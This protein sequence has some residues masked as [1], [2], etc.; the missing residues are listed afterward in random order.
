MEFIRDSLQRKAGSRAAVMV[1]AGF[2][3]N[4]DPVSPSA[5]QM[6]TWT[7]MAQSLC[8]VLYADASV[9]SRKDA[10]NNAMSTSGFLRKSPHF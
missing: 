2:S 10:V 8:R 3:R 5:R 7:D 9:E 4:A 1:G 6:P